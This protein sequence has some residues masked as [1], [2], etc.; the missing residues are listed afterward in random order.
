M[1]DS[2]EGKKLNNLP[3]LKNGKQK[4][5]EK[6]GAE[7][8]RKREAKATRNALAEGGPKQRAETLSFLRDRVKDERQTRVPSRNPILPAIQL[9]TVPS[10]H[11]T[12]A[13]S[14]ALQ[15]KSEAKP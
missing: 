3:T 7:A 2:R 8:T 10:Q 13:Q 15:G 4:R 9:P 14:K 12:R 1:T 5:P 6:R 11:G